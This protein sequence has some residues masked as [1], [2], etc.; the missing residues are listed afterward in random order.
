MRAKLLDMG[1][2]PLGNSPEDM[3]A[4]QKAEVPVWAAMVKASGLAPE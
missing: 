1:F 2:E 4:A 3:A